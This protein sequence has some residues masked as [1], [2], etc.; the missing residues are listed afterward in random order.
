MNRFALTG[1]S[2][3]GAQQWS[4]R[5]VGG[6]AAG[7]EPEVSYAYHFDAALYAA[8][9]RR[10]C[11]GYGL[12]RIEGKIQE[13]RQ[14]PE[15]GF[16]QALV[17]DN[18]QVV[19]GDLFIDCTGGRAVLSEQTLKTGY[20]DWNNWLPSD[21]AVAWQTEATGPAVPYT[22]AIAHRAGWQW[23]IALQ[24]RIGCGTVF[25]SAH[26]SDDEAEA[27]RVAA[28]NGFPSRSWRSI[29]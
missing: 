18:G 21:R 25:S 19:E 14:H 13:V 8:Y 5:W 20:E 24:H 23:S 16:V 15:S 28:S 7:G 11:E 27:T 6:P 29:R 1:Q 4:T 10:R 17:L 12:T 26:M 9:M 2:N 3:A 22:R